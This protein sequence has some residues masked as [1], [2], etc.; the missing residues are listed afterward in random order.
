MYPKEIPLFKE[1]IPYSGRIDA[2]TRW[3]KMAEML[4]WAELDRIY[5]RYFDDGKQGVIK[6][7]RLITG[8][9]VG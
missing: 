1:L 4:P 5:R 9:M 3:I 8:L 6:K 7:C 2:E